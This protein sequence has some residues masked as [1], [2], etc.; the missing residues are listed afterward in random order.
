[1]PYY[2]SESNVFTLASL[3]EAFGIVFVEAMASGLPI[4]AHNGPRQ[5]FVIGENGIFCNT[6]D[7][8]MYAKALINALNRN[9]SLNIRNEA[10][11][12]YSWDNISK[13]YMK[14]FENILR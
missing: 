3:D 8:E 5:K 2:Y 10:I 1:M 6:S 7:P 11:V 12:R 13:E 14:L 4:V 9:K